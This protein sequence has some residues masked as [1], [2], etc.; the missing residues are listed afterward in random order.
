MSLKKRVF[1]V[2]LLCGTAIS[3]FYVPWPILSA[4]LPPLPD[5][6]EAQLEASTEGALDGIV[7]Y[8]D[9]GDGA[10]VTAAVGWH[11]P[12][13]GLPARTDALFKIASIS[14]LYVAVAVTKLAVAGRL[15]LDAPLSTLLPE[16]AA[17]IEHAHRITPRLLVQHR[18]GIPNYTD[19]PGFWTQRP[20]SAEGCLELVLNAAADFEPGEDWAYSNTNYLLLG[21]IMDRVL[22]QPH[23]DYIQSAILDRLGLT[24][25]YAGMDRC[26][27]ADVMSGF[28]VGY[29]QDLKGDEV[30]MVAS[31]ADVARFI[32][33]LNDGRLFD[34]DEAA[35]YSSLYEHEHTGLVPG[36][37][38]TA[39]YHAD[40]DAVV[41]Q[42]STPTDF[43]G[44]NWN[45]AAICYN[46]VVDILRRERRTN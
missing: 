22:G 40:L 16:F 2:F 33:A 36:Y 39:R 17:R 11:D 24:D 10:P 37:Q 8:A 46:R 28:H 45:L 12:A 14:K 34:V 27:E 20:S 13:R 44:Y 3:L 25:T 18:S 5:S 31:A 1:Q 26:N 21:M 4:W 32:R 43:E 23:F 6:V 19:V 15:D 30:G 42:F 9:F 38:S 7:V 35:V 29:P 41:V